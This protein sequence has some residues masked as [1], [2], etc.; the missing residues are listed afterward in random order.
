M[1]VFHTTIHPVWDRMRPASKENKAELASRVDKLTPTG[2]T[3]IH[4]ALEEAFRDPELDTIY[5]L[6]DG[7]PGVGA[8][9]NVEELA[10]EVQRW[11]RTRQVRQLHGISIGENSRLL[12][13]L[14]K[15]SGGT[16]VFHR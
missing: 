3:N 6:T 13:R 5:L 4:D 12:Q 11:N 16:Y 2:G 14:A 1:V 8:I 7:A 15:E 9:T 10:D